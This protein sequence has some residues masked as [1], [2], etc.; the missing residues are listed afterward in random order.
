MH[1][2]IGR[3]AFPGLNRCGFD[4]S[5]VP[6]QEGLAIHMITTGYK[7]AGLSCIGDKRDAGVKKKSAAKQAY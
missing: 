2:P 1:P 5:L 3:L 4:V 6:M 7:K